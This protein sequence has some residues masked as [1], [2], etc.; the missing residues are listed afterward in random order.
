MLFRSLVAHKLLSVSPAYRDASVAGI[1]HLLGLT[2]G[3]PLPADRIGAVRLGTTVA[4][5]A[6]LERKGEPTV[7]VITEGFRDA[8]R[9]AYQARPRIFDRHIVL[10]EQLYDRVVEV[11]ERVGANGDLVRPLDEVAAE[12]AL[13]QAYEDGF[14]AAAIVFMHGY[15][16]P[17]HERRAGEIAR[18][19][20]FTQVSESHEVSPL[21]RLVSRGDTTV[22][23]RKSVV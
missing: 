11:K 12:R 4:T 8:L 22:V 1:R 14:R 15:R 5:N 7:L 6:L 20:G 3:E 17:E 21:M 9:I 13:R 10:P 18:A 2:P 16:Y 19:I 23:D